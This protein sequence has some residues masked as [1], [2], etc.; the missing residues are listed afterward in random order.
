[1][2]LS[3]H[4]SSFTV[5][6]AT[7]VR[8]RRSPPYQL[9]ASLPLALSGAAA[10]PAPAAPGIITTVSDGLMAPADADETERVGFVLQK[11]S[12]SPTLY[13]A[14]NRPEPA[15]HSSPGSV[16]SAPGR[17]RK[18]PSSNPVG[19]AAGLV[20]SPELPGLPSLAGD[21]GE[22]VVAAGTDDIA[23]VTSTLQNIRLELAQG[24]AATRVQRAMRAFLLRKG[25][26]IIM[27]LITKIQ[28]A[29]RGLNTRTSLTKFFK[30]CPPSGRTADLF[31][32]RVYGGHEGG[33]RRGGGY[34]VDFIYCLR[35]T[36]LP[37]PFSEALARFPLE[38]YIPHDTV[39]GCDGTIGFCNQ[40][41]VTGEQ[42]CLPP[43]SS[44]SSSRESPCP[45]HPEHDLGRASQPHSAGAKKK[46]KKTSRT[47]QEKKQGKREAAAREAAAAAAAHAAAQAA[48]QAAQAAALGRYRSVNA[49]FFPRGDWYTLYWDGST[50]DKV[51]RRATYPTLE[52]DN[53]D[54]GPLAERIRRD[55]RE[56]SIFGAER[57][58]RDRSSDDSSSDQD[59]CGTGS[60]SEAN[61]IFDTLDDHLGYGSDSGSGW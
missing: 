21:F 43:P 29:A 56:F 37:L 22:A 47:R 5:C 16:E 26:M 20:G 14:P 51:A 58:R 17:D 35:S 52:H 2:P 40:H 42:L 50:A 61:D 49:W 8:E 53:Y 1:M 23:A 57:I 36:R 39:R 32:S 48:A 38:M 3:P 13:E 31:L 25:T 24:A 45:S 46:K 7:A 10:R 12:I 6:H 27:L 28:A 11:L 33:R 34:V 59:S 30:A 54:P 15:E 55:K 44:P 19:P 41:E 18:V 9:V 4:A 60:T